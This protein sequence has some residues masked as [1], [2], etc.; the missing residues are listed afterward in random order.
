[1]G[2]QVLGETFVDTLH[3][4]NMLGGFT[5]TQEDVPSSLSFFLFASKTQGMVSPDIPHRDVPKA[6]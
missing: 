3:F 2:Q 5:R 4:L 1:M 6:S